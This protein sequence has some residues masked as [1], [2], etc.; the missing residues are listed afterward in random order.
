MIQREFKMQAPELTQVTVARFE[1]YPRQTKRGRRW[2]GVLWFSPQLDPSDLA[3]E[4]L[5]VAHYFLD[6]RGM[7]MTHDSE[8]AYAYLIGH[9]FYKIHP[10]LNY[11]RK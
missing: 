5:H 10:T 1:V 4:C 2:I 11:R 9:L 6:L 8:E 3:H 7:T